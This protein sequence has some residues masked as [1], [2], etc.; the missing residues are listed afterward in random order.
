M[1]EYPTEP[2][3]GKVIGLIAS[4]P[5]TAFSMAGKGEGREVINMLCDAI[6]WKSWKAMRDHPATV[7]LP[8]E[9]GRWVEALRPQW[10]ACEQVPQALPLWDSYLP[11]LQG[12]GYSTWAGVLNTADYGVPQTRER[13]FLLASRVRVAAP[14]IPTHAQHP[15]PTLFGPTQEPWVSMA[16][17]LG[18]PDTWEVEYQRGKGMTERHGE[19]P[20]RPAT[21]PAPTVR[22]GSGGV[23]TGLL[24]HTDGAA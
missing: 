8:L 24:V 23:G 9:V 21:S 13:A 10:L 6:R 4:P 12:L 17:A 3:V 20:N 15:A 19:R 7:W 2:F 22:A 18:W 16:D 11:W 1:S 5:C 14:P